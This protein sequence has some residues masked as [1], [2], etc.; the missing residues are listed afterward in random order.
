[1]RVLV[2][3]SE[4]QLGN[5][6]Q[7]TAPADYDLV[8]IDIDRCD[9]SNAEAVHGLVAEVSPDIIINAAAYTA[10]DK[11]EDEVVKARAV[12]ADAV[13]HLI[14]ALDKKGGAL[15][16]VSTDFV[17]DGQSA[18]AYQPNDKRSPLS[19]YGET[20]MEGEDALR[21]EDLLVRTAWVYSAH[22]ANFVRTMIR[23]M[24]ERSELSVVA[25]Q[26]G[27]P[28]WATSLAST[29]WLLAGKGA[30]GTY[31]Y[32]DAGVASWYDFAVAIAEEA[33]SLG[34][35]GE[36]PVIRPIKTSAYPTKAQRPKFS[37][38]DS[39]ACHSLLGSEPIH[40]RTNL[41]LMLQ[42]EKSLG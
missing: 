22:G 16:H 31:H 3:G 30:K 13:K 7:K 29:I 40:W 9:I 17:F 21:S 18:S 27:S 12:N 35:L 2:T 34:I 23:L 39:S 11:A 4:G 14:S 5:A 8:A 20:K 15:I 42:E 6:L 10:V 32:S 41:R 33:K 28:T 37:L 36:V 25:D 26:I 24:K 38:L 1:M 19:V